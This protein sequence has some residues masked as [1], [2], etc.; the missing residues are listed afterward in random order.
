V[1]YLTVAEVMAKL[2]C[3]RSYAYALVSRLGPKGIGLARVS[4]EALDEYLRNQ[5][6]STDDEKQTAHGSG[7]RRGPKTAS[8][9]AGPRGRR[10]RKPLASSLPAGSE[11]EPIPFTQPRK[12]RRSA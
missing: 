5:C 12:A 2:K 8:P 11:S 3:G 1:T 6:A 10:T 7:G 9:S 4:E